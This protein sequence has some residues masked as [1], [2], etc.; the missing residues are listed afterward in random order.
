MKSPNRLWLTTAFLFAWVCAVAS[1]QAPGESPKAIEQGI[2]ANLEENY[3]ASNAEDLPRLLRSMS[4]EMPQR[5]LFV[6]TCKQEWAVADHYYRL[7]DVQVLE[8]SDAPNAS[9][10]YPYATALVTQQIVLLRKEDAR[11][12]RESCPDGRCPQDDAELAQIFG[13]R[14]RWETSRVHMLF[15]HEGGKWKLVAGL[16]A[17]EPVDQGAESRPEADAVNPI[18]SA[19]N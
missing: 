1:P 14:P 18:G 9:C 15:K 11:A 13:L 2:R 16:T 5:K 10:E 8:H 4:Q 12:I 3:A 19:L 17:P 6:D 7:V